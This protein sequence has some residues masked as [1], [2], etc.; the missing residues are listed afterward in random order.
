MPTVT[1]FYQDGANVVAEYA[2]S[3]VGGQPGDLL[4]YYVHGTNGI[5]ERAGPKAAGRPRRDRKYVL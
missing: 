3:T 4:R 1:Y 5:D 2:K